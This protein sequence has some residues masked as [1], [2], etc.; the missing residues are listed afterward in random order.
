MDLQKLPDQLVESVYSPQLGDIMLEL[1][2]VGLD[3][4]LDVGFI[5][6]LPVVGGLAK[7]FKAGLDVRDRLFLAKVAK[8]LFGLREVPEKDRISFE[9]KILNDPKFKQKVGQTLVLL[10]DRLDDLEKPAIVGKCFSCYLSDKVTFSQ[11]RRLSSA[12]NL[13]FIDDLKALLD[14]K[15]ESSGWVTDVREN[16]SMTGLIKIQ[17]SGALGGGDEIYH[18]LSPLGRLFLNIM[19]D[20]LDQF[21][22]IE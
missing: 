6:D 10:L 9:K 16:L 12:I 7:I 4:L 17:G 14:L 19:T 22:T 2:E 1:S 18:F 11:F 8:F 21:L 20:K 3:Q 13:A 15:V 5:R